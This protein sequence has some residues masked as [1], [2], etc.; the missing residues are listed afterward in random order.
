MSRRQR[1][2]I[3]GGVY[4]VL[5]RGSV[6][7]PIFSQPD[8]YALFERLLAT[9]LRRTDARVHAYC[10]TPT[11]IHLLVQIQE[12][13]VGRLMQGLTSRYARSMHE[14]AGESGHFFKQR[15]RAVLIDPDNYLLKLAHFIHHVPERTGMAEAG[16]LVH[17]SHTAYLRESVVPWLTTRS[18][19]RLLDS[20]EELRRYLDFMSEALAAQDLDLFERAG[21]SDLRVIGSPDFIAGL[22]RHVRTYRTRTSL[23]QIIQTVTST[24]GLEREHV[25]SSSRQRE[26]TLARALIAWYATERGVATLSEVARR[27][28]RDPSTLSM[29]ISRYRV[30]RP[31]LFKLTALHDIVPLAPVGLRPMIEGWEPPVQTR[32]QDSLAGESAAA[33]KAALG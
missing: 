21:A 18:V 13:P 23:D 20:H 14:R 1:L 25:L 10:W 5:Q 9:A 29:A 12:T 4:Y 2:H 15:Y 3:P 6:H 33:P 8:D 22:P 28:R 31:E 26:L 27:M 30:C 16:Q 17:T 19:L 32:D 11:Q 7:Q 24:L